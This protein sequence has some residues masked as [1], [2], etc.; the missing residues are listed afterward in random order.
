[1][2]GVRA[3]QAIVEIERVASATDEV[4]ALIAELDEELS[5]LYMPEQRHGLAL[6]AIFEP[7]IRFFVARLDGLPAGCGGVGLFPTFAEVKRMYVRKALRGRGLADQ[8]L[9]RL[10]VEA[11]DAGLNVLQLET[12]MHS[13]AAI[14]FYRRSGFAPCA[15]FE[16]YASMPPHTVITSVFLEKHLRPAP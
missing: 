11:I 13:E 6:G 14:R 5:G 7:H 15:I 4:R 9:A 10:C 1:M 3:A 12:G 2:A 16:P 8:L